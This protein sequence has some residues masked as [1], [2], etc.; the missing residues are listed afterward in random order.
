MARHSQGIALLLTVITLAIL[1]TTLASL[2]VGVQQRHQAG[3]LALA[4]LQRNLIVDSSAY[5]IF[6][7]T[8]VN[9]TEFDRAQAQT[10]LDLSDHAVLLVWGNE[11]AKANLNHLYNA[12]S[13]ERFS[14]ALNDFR[15][16]TQPS[17][18]LHLDGV[19]DSFNVTASG[20]TGPWPNFFS[21]DQLL[22]RDSVREL[23]DPRTSREPNLL[24][25]ITLWGSGKIDPSQADAATLELAFQALLSPSEARE[26]AVELAG[27]SLGSA[28][29]RRAALQALGPTLDDPEVLYALEDLFVSTPETQSLRVVIDD[30]RRCDIHLIIRGDDRSPLRS[31]TRLRY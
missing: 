18:A 16:A 12:L 23:L 4:K 8:S 31:E 7:S 5:A 2:A 21:F 14:V 22:S 9:E 28:D 6:H 26:A 10:Y 24:D 1:A 13:P 17:L 19:L 25:R 3:H 29:Q 11:N 30:G 15:A 27:Q 20:A